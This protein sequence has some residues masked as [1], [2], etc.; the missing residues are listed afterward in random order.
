[1]IIRSLDANSHFASSYVAKFENGGAKQFVRRG[2]LGGDMTRG[3]GGPARRR[4][5]NQDAS[6]PDR[7]SGVAI[8]EEYADVYRAGYERGRVGENGDIIISMLFPRTQSPAI[9]AGRGGPET[10]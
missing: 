8:E 9:A 1:M 10:R 4:D 6:L 7:L 2:L 5:F 3:L